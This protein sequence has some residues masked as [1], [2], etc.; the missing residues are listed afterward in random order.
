M[1]TNKS[2]SEKTT[3][4]NFLKS[5]GAAVIGGASVLNLG[6][7]MPAYA[8]NTKTLRVGLIGCGGRGTGAANEALNA[9]PDVVLTAMADAFEDRLEKSY[10]NLIKIHPEKVKVPKKN[11]FV[12]FDGYKQVIDSGVDVV[13]LTAPPGF[14]PGHLAYAVDA[15]KH[16]FSEKPVAV[17][18]PGVRQVLES[19]K[20]A[21]EKGLSLVSGFTFR[22]DYAKRALFEKVLGGEIGD[23]KT[24]YAVRNGGFLWYFPRQPEWTDMTYKMRNWYY[25]NWFS[26]DFLV[27]M[28]VHGIDMMCWVMGDKMPLR[29]TGTGGRQVRVEEKWGNIYDHFAIDYEYENE[30]RGF[31]LCRQQA[32]SST[33]NTFEVAGTLGNAFFGG[34]RH[35]I[36]GKNSWQFRGDRNN[37]YQTQH[38]ELFASIRKGNPMNDGVRMAY[39][40]MVAILGRMVAYS[41]QT[42]S[43]EDAFN[44]NQAL[45]PDINQYNWNLKWDGPEVAVPGITKVM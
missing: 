22:Y 31:N 33:R 16:V 38:D 28:V 12:G 23:I 27:E 15:G 18:A 32:G 30:I 39:S 35:E 5:T 13:I 11:K 36:S 41:G 44:S 42:I 2:S 14:R 25:Y 6:L 26:G 4:R 8:R 9:D 19:A 21:K 1:S 3:R 43:F 45:G 7:G 29:A 34:N 10:E 37:P 20:K 24:V 17:D 40:T